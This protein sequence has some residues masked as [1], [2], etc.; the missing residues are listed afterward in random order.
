L[1]V[2]SALSFATVEHLKTNVLE[3]QSA[4]LEAE[5][6]SLQAANKSL[7]SSYMAAIQQLTKNEVGLRQS[8]HQSKEEQLKFEATVDAYNSRRDELMR[9][10]SVSEPKP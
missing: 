5:I 4:K 7:S 10:P 6:A 2:A 3:A 8:L 1:A 9:G